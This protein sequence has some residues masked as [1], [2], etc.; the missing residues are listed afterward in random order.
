MLEFAVGRGL[1][2]VNPWS[3][4]HLPE[5]VAARDRVL[6]P[7]EWTAVRDWALAKPYPWGPF[8]LTLMLTA[9]RLNEVAGMRWDEI[10]G[11]LWT[12]PGTRHKSG[13]A[14][15]VPLP[16]QV[17]GILAAQPHVSVFVFSST[18]AKPIVPGSKLLRD[19]KTG[20]KTSDWRFHDLRRTA[21]TRMTERGVTRFAVERVLG[22]TDQSVTA[23]YDRN[24]YREEKRAALARLEFD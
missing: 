15:E 9:Q 14:H 2:E 12:V 13:R 19:I 17:A 8:L 10:D 6:K 21:A 5:G 20:T 16:C 11:D 18:P 3:A 1:L 24:A 22:H 4:L 23:R 7:A